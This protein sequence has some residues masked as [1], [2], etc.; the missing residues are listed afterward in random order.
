MSSSNNFTNIIPSLI[1]KA[2]TSTINHQLAAALIKG[3]KMVSSPCANI[4]RNRCRGQQCGSLH[5]EAHAILTHFGRDLSFSEK[6]G[7]CYQPRKGKK[8]KDKEVG[9]YRYPSY[10]SRQDL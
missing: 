7:W 6:L 9:Y 10:S 5:A 8:Y 2:K 4:E 1:T 3:I